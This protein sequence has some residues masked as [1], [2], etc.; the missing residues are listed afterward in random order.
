MNLGEFHDRVARALGRGTSL[1]ASIPVWVEEAV[2]EI[3]NNYTF[4]YMKRWV[5]ISV[6]ADAAQAHIISLYNTPIKEIASLRYYNSDAERWVPIKGPKNE[7]DRLTRPAGFPSSF[8]LNGVNGVVLDAIPDE[9][10]TIEGNL[11]VFSS[12]QAGQDAFEHY[13]IDRHRKLLL[14]QAV[15]G[16]N[17]ELRDPRLAQIYE[18]M[19]Q[20][21][22]TG[23]NVAEEALQHG[24][25][26]GAQMDW[27][28]PYDEF[29]EN[30]ERT[31]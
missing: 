23:V 25:D 30:F 29:D 21:A 8:W 28:P 1:D 16:A 22:W 26:T 17:M 9:D 6:D 13:L 7:Q 4:Q 18:A 14:S 11:R 20:K 27:E 24:G 10:Y 12:W 5:E 19:N 3:E 31:R 15:L 2:Q